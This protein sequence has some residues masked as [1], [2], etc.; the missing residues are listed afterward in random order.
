MSFM[1]E[2]GLFQERGSTFLLHSTLIGSLDQHIEKNQKGETL[3]L[4]LE[5]QLISSVR[6]F[7]FQSIHFRLRYCHLLT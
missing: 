3:C 1:L 5:L 2:G 4:F 7:E 6:K